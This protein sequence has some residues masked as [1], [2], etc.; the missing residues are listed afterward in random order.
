MSDKPTKTL[1]FIAPN[2]DQLIINRIDDIIEIRLNGNLIARTT[3]VE[4]KERV[5][6]LLQKTRQEL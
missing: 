6:N 5:V 1:A 3:T 2:K 4:F